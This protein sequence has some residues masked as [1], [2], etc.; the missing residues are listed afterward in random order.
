MHKKVLLLCL[1]FF[2]SLFYFQINISAN[3][4]CNNINSKIVN[5]HELPNAPIW[6]KK[7]IVSRVILKNKFIGYTSYPNVWS[8]AT[9]YTI[10][11]GR[12]LT[13]GTSFNWKT[14]TVYVSFSYTTSGTTRFKANS[15]RASRLQARANVKIIKWKQKVFFPSL[16]KIKTV[17]EKNI[18]HTT[19]TISVIYKK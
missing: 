8:K 4:I 17:R 10:S 7:K 12:S 14:I 1:S 13:G 19:P 16:H 6:M 9:G 18:T 2:I 5:P 11:G 15:K 3:S